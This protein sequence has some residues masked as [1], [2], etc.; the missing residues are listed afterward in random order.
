[1]GSLL[2]TVVPAASLF[3]GMLAAGRAAGNGGPFLVKYPG[4]DPA[5]KGVLARL[6]PTLKPAQETRLRVVQEDLTI[7][8][9]RRPSSAAINRRRRA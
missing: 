2:K 1:M 3:L 6:D 8:F 4:G 9:P 7:M 5:A